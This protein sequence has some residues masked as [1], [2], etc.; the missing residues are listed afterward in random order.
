LYDGTWGGGPIP[1][2]ISDFE[3]MLPDGMGWSWQELQE[4]PLYVQRFCWDL[5]QIRREAQHAANER[6]SSGS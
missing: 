2:E 3:L 5:L 1:R 6:A 4:T